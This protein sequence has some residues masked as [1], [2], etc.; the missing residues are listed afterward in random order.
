M[1]CSRRHASSDP[2]RIRQREAGSVSLE[3]IGALPI[4]LVSVLIAAQIGIAGYALW[5]AGTASRAGARAVLTGKGPKGAAER[6]LPPVLR[7]GLEVSGRDPVKV[8]V[9]IPRLMPLLPK[10]LVYASSSLG[11]R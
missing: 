7:G 11:E 8:G 9:Q 10:K 4:V 1:F 3:L 5:S 6:S 2:L